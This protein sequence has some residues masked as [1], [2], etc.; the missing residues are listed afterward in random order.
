MTAC[1]F[2]ALSVIAVI[3]CALPSQV[4]SNGDGFFQSKEFPG[5]PQFVIFGNVKD[6]QGKYL[7]NASITIRVEE[8]QLFFT[9]QTDIL[10]RYRTPDVGRA[11]EDLGYQVDPSLITI[12]VECPGY[13]EVRREYRGKFRQNHG[14]IEINFLMAKTAS[15][16]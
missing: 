6:D 14:P 1:R 9:V 10:G 7:D 5:K 16:T 13:R 12:A 11:I 2:T 3:A 4:W 15:Q 8:H